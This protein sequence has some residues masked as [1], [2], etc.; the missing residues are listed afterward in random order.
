MNDRNIEWCSNRFAKRP[1][2]FKSVSMDSES[3]HSWR[4]ENEPQMMYLKKTDN[5]VQKYDEELDHLKKSKETAA[6][7]LRDYNF[8]RS[9][10]MLFSFVKIKQ[11]EKI[12]DHK[13]EFTLEQINK[14]DRKN[15][16]PL[17][18]AVQK[19]YYDIVKELLERGA[20]VNKVC[21]NNKDT[22]LHKACENN[23]VE[24]VK[25]L[26]E[27]GA[28]Y[29]AYNLDLKTPLA[30]ATKEVKEACYLMAEVSQVLT[31]HD[32]NQEFRFNHAKMHNNFE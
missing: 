27:Y 1:Q 25:L 20:E 32:F 28:D 21:G 19:N 6:V 13:P 10:N 5:Q 11:I 2:L 18:Y 30:V 12:R 4:N 22:V 24:I 7:S 23:N 26:L 29:T 14:Y 8:S 9:D 15:Q 17:W 16:T 3:E 31:A